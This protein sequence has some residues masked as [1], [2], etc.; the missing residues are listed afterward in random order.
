MFALN[1]RTRML[2]CVV[3]RRMTSTA[4]AVKA[5]RA[6][7]V[8]L[9]LTS[10]DSK[11]IFSSIPW[12]SS[13]FEEYDVSV[14]F[15]SSNPNAFPA[16]CSAA[17]VGSKLGFRARAR[18]I[19]ALFEKQDK[20][21][22]APH[23]CTK[24][25]ATIAEG[26]G[27]FSSPEFTRADFMAGCEDWDTAVK[28]AFDEHKEAVARGVFKTPTHCVEGHL[29]AEKTAKF[30]MEEVQTWRERLSAWRIPTARLNAAAM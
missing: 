28:P 11:N 3:D 27:L 10:P 19:R 22:G 21:S 23:V 13:S 15:M 1:A 12:I 2:R 14:H 17:L 25:L 30:G 24:D 7:K 29:L 26:C 9:D 5:S 8:Y 16:Q 20:F 18:Y 6:W 4:S